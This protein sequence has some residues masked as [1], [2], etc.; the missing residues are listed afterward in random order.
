MRAVA[1]Q[2]ELLASNTAGLEAVEARM[3]VMV[4]LMV[5][6]HIRPD[7]LASTT[8]PRPSGSA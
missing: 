6:A 5:S 1:A 4:Q 8:P 3:N 7:V 2:N